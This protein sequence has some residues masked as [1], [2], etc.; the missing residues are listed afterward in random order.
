MKK[1][2]NYLSFIRDLISFSP[3]QLER[4]Q[5][6]ADFIIAFLKSYS[7]DYYLDYFWAKVPKIEKEVLKA[8]TSEIAC[9]GSSFVSGKIRSKDYLISSLIFSPTLLDQSNINF[10]PQCLAI[11]LASFYFA[12]AIAISKKD[13]NLILKAKK[14]EGEVKV[15]P[16]RYKARNIL[17]GNFKNPKVIFFA[18]YDSIGKGAIDNASG[19]ATLMGVILSRPEILKDNL[20]VFAANEELS[21]DRPIYWGHGFRIFEKNFFNIMKRAKEILVVD[22]VGNGPTKISQDQNLI[23]LAFPIKNKE[24]LQNKIKIIS[25]DIHKLMTLYHSDLDDINKIDIKYL[26]EASKIISNYY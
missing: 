17:V 8:D 15:K 3:R 19:V 24:R 1:K 6:T 20:F 21:Y 10:N 14:V 12:P 7:F 23:R 2:F 22:C 11:S 9:K 4:E 5:K 26:A 18:H 13:L 25:G 16:L